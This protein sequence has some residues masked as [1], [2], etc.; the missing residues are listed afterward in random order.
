[1][2]GGSLSG[3][4]AT[5]IGLPNAGSYQLDLA[6]DYVVLCL[7]QASLDEAATWL[8]IANKL[9]ANGFKNDDDRLCTEAQQMRLDYYAAQLCYRQKD[10]PKAKLLNRKILQ[11]SQQQLQSSA[12]STPQRQQAEVYSLNWLV[13]IA[14]KE[15]DVKEADRLLQQSWPIIQGGKDLR[16]QAFHQRSKAKLAK[17]TGNLADFH[18]WSKQA[19]D[20]FDTLGMHPQ[21]QEM[22]KWLM[23]N[24]SLPH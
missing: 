12:V 13:D 9:I 23:E 21:S 4:E 8:A 1:M 11:R 3:K 6:I 5:D 10:Y 2:S 19:L 16:S 7:F 14:L 15:N 20:C 22:H 18:H 17:R 24:S